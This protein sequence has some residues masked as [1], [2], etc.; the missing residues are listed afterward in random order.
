MSENKKFIRKMMIRLPIVLAVGALLYFAFPYLKPEVEEIPAE[1]TL[2]EAE[3]QE[4]IWVDSIYNTLTEDERIGQTFMI[5]AHSN[6]GLDHEQKV[7]G[8][9]KDYHVGG[10]C[11]FQG[12]PR[13]QAELLNGYQANAR[14]PLMVSMDAEWGLGMRFKSAGISFPRQLALG[15]ISDNRLIYDMGT[16]VARQC[17]RLGVHVNFAPVVDINNNPDNPVINNRSFGEDR[18]NVTA[19]SYMYATGM[20]DNGI[21]A[22]AKHFPGHGDTDVDSH[23]DLP[24]IPHGFNRLDSVEM[25]P[26]KVLAQQ[27][28]QSVMM[29]HLSIPVLDDT[30]NLPSSLSTK[31]T[32]DLLKEKIGFEGL[33]FTDGLGMQG[34]RKHFQ[35]GEIEVGALVAGN[36]VL[37]LP[38]DVPV[39]YSAIKK[40]LTDGTLSWTRVEEAVKKILR[41]KYRLGLTEFTPVELTNIER[42]LNTP[43][44]LILKEKLIQQSLTTV[45][46]QDNILP[47]KNTKNIA[48]L[49]IGETTK[50]DFQKSV[51]QYGSITHLNQSKNISAAQSTTL[52]NKLKSK[53]LVVVSLHD[54]SS[55]SKKEFGVPL[56]VRGFLEKLNRQNKVILVI[57]GSPYSLRYFDNFNH[58]MVAYREDDMVQNVTA[59][60]VFGAIPTN[61]KLP[62][63]ASPLSTYGMGIP[64][65]NL[66]RLQN[67]L[68]EAVGI[69]GELLKAGIDSIANHAIQIKATPGCVVL[70]AK[71]RKII[72]QEAY[73]HHTQAKKRPM[74]TDDIF[75]LASVTK[76]AATTL[77][78]MKLYDEGK[79][80]INQRM[81]TYMPELRNTN[82]RD[83][84]IK[85]VLAHR[86]RLHSWIP[87]YEETK[88]KKGNLK[89]SVYHGKKS[90]QYNIQVANNIYMNK[91]YVDT[92]WKR[93][94]D[95]E[96]RDKA[97][98][99]YSDL[100]M[101]MFSKMIKDVAG[102]PLNEYADEQFYT[103]LGLETM[104]FLPLKKY[105]KS[106]IVPSEKD[107]YFRGQVIRGHV[108]DMGAAMLGG[109]SGHAGLFGSAEDL[110]VILQMLLN[111]GEYGGTRYLQPSTVDLFTNR[112]PDETRRGLG[113]DMKQT[114]RR[115]TANMANSATASTFGHSGFTGIIVWADKDNQLIYIFLSNRTYPTMNN[116]KLG[117]EDIRPRIQQKI[118]DAMGR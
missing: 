61:G 29:A 45:R 96:L 62:I 16:E 101:I 63:T 106:R 4:Q 87:F 85:D 7:M 9:V 89:T 107:S 21:M 80:D 104:T 84:V 76:V 31:I 94:H 38:P 35:P 39:A 102:K 75:D 6:K 116:F 70:V 36:D 5:R 55:F 59:Q 46:N 88:T 111:G 103:P 67:G 22:C 33:I 65:A 98:Y 30:P 13:K 82:K 91:S 19:K 68:P 73:G 100:G 26:F 90:T 42:D 14:L 18:Y 99:K 72:F 114:D 50:T 20:Q 54:M 92:I 66:M 32:T 105:D 79:I 23:Y 53:D 37:L 118:Y 58:V 117:R 48:T 49:A 112:H 34:A 3:I 27:K 110:A 40:A 69:N 10:L 74:R 78:L 95:S 77:S 17:K 24:I 83:V 108:H 2:T 15:A 51:D 44:A 25:Y 1:D 8:L 57:F 86:A 64:T 56:A 115:E 113:F 52:L 28:I 97:G 71:D 43:Q 81:S 12:T 41:S 11:F 60:A 47:I 93:I 109:V